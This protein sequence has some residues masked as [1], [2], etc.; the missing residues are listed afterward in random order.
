MITSR[1]DLWATK[2]NRLV[3]SLLTQLPKKPWVA[4][5]VLGGGEH[6]KRSRGSRFVKMKGGNQRSRRLS[7]LETSRFIPM[8]YWFWILLS[9]RFATNYIVLELWS[10]KGTKLADILYVVD[11]YYQSCAPPILRRMALPQW[12]LSRPAGK[13]TRFSL[14]I[15]AHTV[16]TAMDAT[17]R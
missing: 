5:W 17:L 6:E 11:G 2:L 15:A 14:D 10:T 13:E 9:C 4:D 16:K 7:L 12:S 8:T 3:L 1:G